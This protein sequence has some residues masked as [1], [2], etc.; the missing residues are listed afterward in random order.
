MLGRVREFRRFLGTAEKPQLERYEL[1]RAN[2]LA[3]F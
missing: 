2:K 1:I 3:L